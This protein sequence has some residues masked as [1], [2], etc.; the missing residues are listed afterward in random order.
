[1][2]SMSFFASRYAEV[3]NMRAASLL[4]DHPQYKEQVLF[5]RLN[6]ML[7]NFQGL[8]NAQSA[9]HIGDWD[10]S[11]VCQKS[12]RRRGIHS[13]VR[14]AK[15][16]NY[17]SVG[18]WWLRLNH[19]FSEKLAPYDLLYMQNHREQ[20]LRVWRNGSV[21]HVHDSLHL[22]SQIDSFLSTAPLGSDRFREFTAVA[23]DHSASIARKRLGKSGNLMSPIPIHRLM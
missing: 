21:A 17:F 7:M 10:L 3:M 5:P 4:A 8:W 19:S 16:G 22:S 14:V 1:M 2:L 12:F 18:K 20:H 6:R 11:A 15:L 23:I 9:R 13:W